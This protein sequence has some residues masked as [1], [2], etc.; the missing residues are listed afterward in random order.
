MIFYT[1]CLNLLFLTLFGSVIEDGLALTSKEK[2]VIEAKQIVFNDFPGA[3]NPSIFEFEDHYLLSFRYIPDPEDQP[4]LSQIGVVLLNKA[5][6]PISSP[7]LLTTRHSGDEV[8][9]QAEDARIFSYRG[10]L[11]LIYNDCQEAIF[12]YGERRDMVIAELFYEEKRF[13]LSLPLKLFHVEKYPYVLLQKNWVP[14][15]Y[16]KQLFMG[17]TIEPHEILKVN[18][19]T[20]AC[21]KVFES[22]TAFFWP[23][24][25]LRGSSAPQLVDGEYFAFFHSGIEMASNASGGWRQWHYFM[26]AYTFSAEPPFQ[27]KRISKLPIVAKGFYTNS[28][29]YKKVIFPGGFVAVGDFFYVAYSK[30]DQEIWI[31][32][33]DK[34]ALRRTMQ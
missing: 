15:E 32:K 33:I 31:A 30:D 14:F 23:W 29:Y 21:H 1:L 7:Q 28:T 11:F 17:Y 13:S 3:H 9:P 16:Q 24:G 12:E 4:W 26:G 22:K 20:G 34:E 6:E 18:L 25:P 8:P 19:L 2:V 10:R 5:F 27:I